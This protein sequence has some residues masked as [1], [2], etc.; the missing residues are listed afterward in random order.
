M[1]GRRIRPE[2]QHLDLD[3]FHP[4][5]HSL[6]TVISPL[7]KHVV[8]PLKQ[9]LKYLLLLF[10]HFRCC[11]LGV[12]IIQYSCLS[13][14]HFDRLPENEP[15]NFYMYN[16]RAWAVKACGLPEQGRWSSG[17]TQIRDEQQS[18]ARHTPFFSLN[19]LVNEY[20]Y[21]VPAPLV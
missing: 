20:R 11:T 19:K 7:L 14:W 8:N 2:P 18:G 5:L 3:I 10:Q 1:K 4:L 13:Q 15:V 6:H 17:R 12:R 9:P 16:W 21:G